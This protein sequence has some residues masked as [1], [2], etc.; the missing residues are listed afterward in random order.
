MATISITIADAD[1][2]RVVT[3][4]CGFYGYQATLTDILGNT[5]PNPETPNQF[6]RRMIVQSIKS[7]CATYESQ[8]AAATASGNAVNSANLLGVS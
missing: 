5:T 3:D 7:A 4:L 1:L 2:S 8:Q 6:A